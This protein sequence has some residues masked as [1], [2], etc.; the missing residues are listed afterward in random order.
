MPKF[1]W[2]CK[3]TLAKIIL[4]KKNKGHLGAL[5]VKHLTLDFGLGHDLMVVEFE[6]CVMSELATSSEEPA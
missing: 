5:A 6:P 4:K 2:N 3:K 1:V